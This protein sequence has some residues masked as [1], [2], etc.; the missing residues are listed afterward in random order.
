MMRTI[1]PLNKRSTSTPERLALIQIGSRSSSGWPGR[2]SLPRCLPNGN[3]VGARLCPA[4]GGVCVTPSSPS[5]PSQDVTGDVYYF[6]FSTGQSTWDHPCDE[7][8]RHMVTQE[9]ERAQSRPNRTAPAASGSAPSPAP[10]AF[11]KDKEKKKKKDKKEKKKEK[12]KSEQE[13]LKAPGAHAQSAAAGESQGRDRMSRKGRNKKSEA[14]QDASRASRAFQPGLILLSAHLRAHLPPSLSASVTSTPPITALSTTS[15][16]VTSLIPTKKDL[17]QKDSIAAFIQALEGAVG[18]VSPV[19]QH[20]EH[21][22]PIYFPIPT[23]T[24]ARPLQQEEREGASEQNVDETETMRQSR[25]KALGPLAPLGSLAPLRGVSDAPVPA[26]RGSLGSGAGLQPLKT[27][28]GGMVSGVSS[29][30]LRGREGEKPS[31]APPIF[32][33]DQEEDE[34]DEEQERESVHESLR[35]SSR[36]LQNLHLDLNALGDGLQY[37]DSEVSGTGPAEERTEPE[38]Q[39]LAL[40]GDHSPEPPSQD[41]FRGRHISSKPPGS[42]RDCS[43]ADVFPPS[44]RDE[45]LPHK[46]EDKENKTRDEEKDEREEEDCGERDEEYVN[47]EEDWES[48]REEKTEKGNEATEGSEGGKQWTGEHAD[49]G[50]KESDDE[51]LEEIG[52]EVDREGSEEGEGD[53]LEKR[54]E[55][56]A[57]KTVERFVDKKGASGSE[58]SLKD[59]DESKGGEEERKEGAKMKDEPMILDKSE[60]DE[61]DEEVLERFGEKQEE[62]Q[63]DDHKEKDESEGGEE[64]LSKEERKMDKN[65]LKTSEESESEIIERFGEKQDESGAEDY[66]EKDEKNETEGGEEDVSKKERKMDK[67]TLEIS[68]GCES[69]EIIERF[70]EKQ[71]QKQESRASKDVEEKRD[72]EKVEKQKTM[73]SSEVDD[74]DGVLERFGENQEKSKTDE[75]QDKDASLKP[76]GKEDYQQAKETE[77]DESE[78]IIERFGDSGAEDL[79]E[80]DKKEDSTKEAETMDEEKKDVGVLICK[81]SK[82]FEQDSEEELERYLHSLEKEQ[83]SEHMESE[84]ADEVMKGQTQ[85]QDRVSEEKV[86]NSD[87]LEKQEVIRKNEKKESE[88][89]VE[90]FAQSLDHEETRTNEG[91]KSDESIEEC[92]KSEGEDQ[93]DEDKYLSDDDDEKES[94]KSEANL[95]KT[96]KPQSN[97]PSREEDIERFESP[98]LSTTK[99]QRA[100][101]APSQK[102]IQGKKLFPKW[103][104]LPS[105]ESEASEH[106]EEAS[107]HSNDIKM[108]FRSKFSENILDLTDLPP[109]E[110]SG[111]LDEK[112]KDREWAEDDGVEFGVLRKDAADRHLLSPHLDKVSSPPSS[113]SL[114][115]PS[116]PLHE[117]LRTSSINSTPFWPRPDTARGRLTRS[118]CANDEEGDRKLE[119]ER[120]RKE[121]E[122]KKRQEQKE[123]EEEERQKREKEREKRERE[124]RDNIRGEKEYSCLWL[125]REQASEEDEKKAEEERRM[126]KRKELEERRREEE[127]ET[128]RQMEE[129]RLKMVE[130][131]ERRLCLLRDEL[132]RGEE[133]EERRMKEE[134][135]ERIRAV[136]QRLQKERR[137]EEDRLE[138]ETQSKLHQFRE[139]SRKERETQIHTL[140]EENEARLREMRS[141]LEAE[142][143]R[144]E[145]QRKRDLETLRA[146]SEEELAA[147]R[148]QLQDRRE[149]QLHSLRLEGRASDR[150]RELRSPRPE[151]QL[152]EYQRELSDV[153]QEV[154]EEVQREHNRKLEQIKED[155]RQQLHTI[156]VTHMEEESMQ[157]ERL[158]GSLQEER[159]RM[160]SSHSAQL[161]QL[162]LQLDSQLHNIRKTH[163]H[164][165]AE[166]QEMMEQL[167]LKAK[168]LKT[169]ETRLQAQAAD[170]KKRRQLLGDEEDEV[171]R[172][173]EALPRLLKERDRLLAELERMRD[174]RDRA[175]D[176]LEREK[177]ERKRVRDELEREKGER[178]KEREENGRTREERERLQTKVSLLQERCDRLSRRVSELEQRESVEHVERKKEVEKNGEK[179]EMLRVDDLQPPLSPAPVSRDSQSSIDDLREYISCEGVSL[180]RA[181]RFLESQ[182]GSLRERQAALRAAHTSLQDPTPGGFTSQLYDNLEQEASH[183]EELRETVQKGHTLLRKKEERLNQLETSLVE[184]LSCD[185][186]ERL[187]GDRKVTFDVTDSEISSAYGHEGTAPTVPV[188]VQQLADSLQHI[189]GQ[190]NTVLGALGSLTQRTAP[191]LAAHAPLQ[192]LSQPLS[193]R[194]SSLPPTSMW[195]WPPSPASST[196]ITNQNG[197]A[198]SSGVNGVTPSRGSSDLLFNSHWSRFLPGSSMDT[199]TAIPTRTHTPYYGY[200][201][202]SLSSIQSKSSEM[203]SQTL[204]GLIEGNKRWLET[205]RK[206]PSMP[207]FS[208]YRTPS[209]TSGLVQLSLDENNQIKVYHY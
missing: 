142:R 178:R 1:S 35:G 78:E 6:N 79:V 17:R 97:K 44:S 120:R 3:P 87:D 75:P 61:S 55:S 80:E 59:E 205:R 187:A 197:F 77:K 39:D 11:K 191:P 186:G 102:G 115:K 46:E 125:L 65:M 4:H 86:E 107:D 140:R 124:D 116:S 25:L 155:H 89:Q 101:D 154:R 2:V 82:E 127:K 188:K 173:I 122:E 88:E 123:R 135:E 137:E 147:E 68:E 189:S 83:Q 150:Q 13:V 201:P 16:M 117:P 204:Q 9:R 74:S 156:R 52:E 105:E 199:S 157:R 192:P 100:L 159:E 202:K 71:Q 131:R 168:E 90:R 24:P 139:Q 193:H 21:Y 198:H 43:S 34:V 167:E 152:S 171:E 162:R 145:V 27:P 158:L 144:L 110:S 12:K 63:A 48:Q 40:S 126:Q 14:G 32:Q 181:R 73:E 175:R 108:G 179:E 76:E 57:S 84:D 146:E 133:E 33:S 42:S 5:L 121:A 22:K 153:L 183:L 72:V 51:I 177:E 196:S 207:L 182:T 62:S 165:E 172:G 206:D 161:E 15:H 10:A 66:K 163:T 109:A 7:Q 134:K 53:E 50:K 149:E 58:R 194:S 184:E 174:E 45:E 31:L 106:I 111:K 69:D 176:E 19:C 99:T 95:H 49:E 195:A 28:F 81:E 96:D 41:S 20:L 203:D 160:L 70:G 169:Q 170:L 26:L 103:N 64:E 138:Q 164:K 47:R 29:S 104:R 94:L 92:V 141:E 185:D 93:K 85:G 91:E 18:T 30:L 118:T 209:S 180:Q 114:S 98:K 60:K 67:D 151:Q 208:R 190:L 119:E 112:K 38:L 166:V 23:S 143:E 130:E 8:Y 113:S 128:E 56:D 148:R 37:E 200:T 129:E 132:R 54:N 136:K 36:L